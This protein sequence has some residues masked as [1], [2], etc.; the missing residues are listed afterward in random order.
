[1]FLAQ[2]VEFSLRSGLLERVDGPGVPVDELA[3]ALGWSGERL[4]GLLRYLAVEG[5]VTDPEGSPA[6]TAR[7]RELLMFRAWYELLVG[8]YGSSLSDLDTLMRSDQ[9]FASR[10]SA[11]V[12]KGSC[13]ISRYDAIPMVRRLLAGAD[14]ERP[15]VLVDLGCGDGTFLLDLCA[16]LGLP[17]VGVDPH[18]PSVVTGR[19]EAV[20]RG[21]ADRVRFEAATAENFVK[22]S[23]EDR[24]PTF[25][26]AFS[27]QEV[28][29]QQGR[30]AVVST[31]RTILA[32]PGSQL[33]VVEVD[34]RPTDPSVMHHGLGIAYYNP[35][36]L[37]HQVT[38]QRLETRAF[39]ADVFAEAGATVVAE[40]TPDPRVDST[41]LELGYLLRGTGQ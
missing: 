6:L 27:L 5:V 29:E 9:E 33:V 28:L 35:Y 16:E 21:L 38:E 14:A 26:A 22:S 18:E 31:V 8:G 7:G 13:G 15:S 12:G 24:D 30:G 4:R 37:L 25:V 34:H 19:E 11:M 1:M 2:V 32:V 17:G 40:A 39:W 20:R 36:Y 10:D 3:S 23:V 41:G